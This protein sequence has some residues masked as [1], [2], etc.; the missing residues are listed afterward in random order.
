MIP[1]ETRQ[2]ARVTGAGSVGRTDER[3]GIHATDLGIPWDGGDGRIYLLFGDTYGRGWGGDG[4]GP[5]DADWRCNVLAFS[6]TRELGDGLDLEDVVARPDGAATQV[7]P[8]GSGREATVIP[9]AGIAVDGV[10]YVHYMSVREWGPPGRWRTNYAGIA[11]S[12]DGGR[13]WDKPRSARWPNRWWAESRFQIGAFTRD[14]R[15]VY[16]YGTTNG[17]FDDAYLAR[18]SPAGVADVSAYEY[19]TGDGWA[20]GE[21]EAAPVFPG[22]VGELS[23]GYN[24]HFGLWLA[25]HLDEDRAAI[26][27]R[28]AEHPEGPWTGG[29]V[30]VSGQDYPA[31]YGGYLHP[32]AMDSDEIYFL[33][34]QWGPYNVFLLRTRLS[35]S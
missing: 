19:W 14:A 9:N 35:E 2:I 18:V 7:I 28:T 12:R 34:S 20:R 27:L 6:R 24:V 11:V 23:V 33:L 5:A 17:R 26:V 15:H 10:Q 29:E 32:W 22:P 3:F 16:L 21:K 31:L 1:L 8:S 13:T 25:M 30:V 4:G